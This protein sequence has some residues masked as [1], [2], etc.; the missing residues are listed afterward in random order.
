[1]SI[2]V[3]CHT[4]TVPSAFFKQRAVVTM[5]CCRNMLCARRQLTRK[6]LV[7]C[8][9]ASNAVIAGR[10]ICEKQGA[11]GAAILGMKLILMNRIEVFLL[12]MALRACPGQ[13]IDQPVFCGSF[14][15]WK[16]FFQPLNEDVL[17][18]TH[19]EVVT[20]ENTKPFAAMTSK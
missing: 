3:F 7:W 12:P 8:G 18:A 4:L 5:S 19:H 6:T 15:Q 9:V 1:M 2:G 14:R 13:L 10:L 11:A 17:L 16:R 20:K